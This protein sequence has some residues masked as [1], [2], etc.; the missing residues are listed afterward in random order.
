MHEIFALYQPQVVFHAAAYKHG[1]VMEV[2]NAWQAVRN[3]VVGTWVV[4]NAAI[5]HNTERFVLISTD[6][7][8]NPT[9]VMGTTKRMAEMVC[10]ALQA[11]AQRVQSNQSVGVDEGQLERSAGGTKFQMVRFGN[12]LGSTG[13]VIPRFEQQIA[14]GG[15]VTV[16]HPDVTRYFMSIPEA[17]LL[18]LQA[19][20]M[21]TGGEIFVLDMG[22]PVKI[23]T[24]AKNLI[25]LAGHSLDD[26]EII[27]TGLRPGEKM[28]EEL[29]VD[30][31]QTIETPHAKLRIARA[32]TAPKGLLD[33][34]REWALADEGREDEDVRRLLKEWVKEYEPNPEGHCTT[35]GAEQ[36]DA[37]GRAK[38]MAENMAGDI[39]EDTAGG[40]ATPHP[41]LGGK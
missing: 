19:A 22:E 20:A 38:G 30:E 36:G 4:A 35:E 5:Q 26:I 37:K 17:A 7:A 11:R 39:S 29:L 1:P 28:F 12:V 41:R 13:S 8:V 40:V 9:N 33:T 10:Q 16:T 27:Y 14:Q 31:E 6:K 34:V 3:N 23:D 21:G 25:Q 15:P 2:G 32:R 24:L 18:V